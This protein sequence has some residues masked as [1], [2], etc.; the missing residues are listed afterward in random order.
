[1][2]NKA[3]RLVVKSI[4][5]ILAV[6]I[7]LWAGIYLLDYGRIWSVVV[8]VIACFGVGQIVYRLLRIID[9]KYP[10]V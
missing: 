4:I 5:V 9:M 10:K 6:E 1:M 3:K 8:F 2:S 7:G